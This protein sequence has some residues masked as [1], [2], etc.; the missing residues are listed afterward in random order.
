MGGKIYFLVF[1]QRNAKTITVA[2]SKKF[3][4]KN[5]Q[6]YASPIFF[7]QKLI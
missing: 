3:I 4:E 2:S 5:I 7:F 6:I 1:N